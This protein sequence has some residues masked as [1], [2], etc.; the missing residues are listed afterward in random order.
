ML[1]IIY[2]FTNTAVRLQSR[3]Y[4]SHFPTVQ[5]H[6][7]PPSV[8]K[9]TNKKLNLSCYVCTEVAPAVKK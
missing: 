2:R 1:C 9:K 6:P 4:L 8:V 7:P 5:E 3:G